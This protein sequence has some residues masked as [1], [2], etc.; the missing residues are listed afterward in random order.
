MSAPCVEVGR[1]ASQAFADVQA[2]GI[3]SILLGSLAVDLEPNAVRRRRVDPPAI[4][5]LVDQV[6]PPSSATI[7]GLLEDLPEVETSATIDDRHVNRIAVYIDIEADRVPF[8]QLRV[9]DGVRN[10]FARQ[11]LG[12]GEPPGTEEAVE[13]IA[14]GLPRIRNRYGSRLERLL[15]H[16]GL[17]CMRPTQDT[18][19]PNFSDRPMSPVD[20]VLREAG[21]FQAGNA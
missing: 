18:R 11:Q 10:E 15:G 9:A 6:E 21:D 17:L 19:R 2:T 1:A 7:S 14:D 5:H 8:L 13:L 3:E 20:E 4:R 12:F 16:A